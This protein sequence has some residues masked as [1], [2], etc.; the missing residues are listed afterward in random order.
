MI[1][2]LFSQKRVQVWNMSFFPC[3]KIDVDHNSLVSFL[4]L[5]V[6]DGVAFLKGLRL[7]KTMYLD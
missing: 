4:A 2:F 5:G 6:G 1:I 3:S 7:L